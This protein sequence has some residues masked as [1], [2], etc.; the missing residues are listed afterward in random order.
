MPLQ[1]LGY[2]HAV[3]G[4]RRAAEV[5]LARLDELGRMTYVS[6]CCRAAIHAGLGDA[7]RCFASLEDAFRLRSRSMAWLAVSREYAP[8]RS[9]PRFGDLVRRI[10]IPTG[11]RSRE[12][13]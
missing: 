13:S 8:L 1:G 3:A 2:A 12:T 11:G 7:D 6:P 5:V 9:D 4:D 10:G